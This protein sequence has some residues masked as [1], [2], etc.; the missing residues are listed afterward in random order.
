MREMLTVFQN[1]CRQYSG[2]ST[3]QS[4]VSQGI[5]ADITQVTRKS[6]RCGIFFIVYDPAIKI[7]NNT[8]F[9]NGFQD[10]TRGNCFVRIYR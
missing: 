1:L 3:T 2:K 5:A 9:I 6:K 8:E 7:K 4:V 10:D